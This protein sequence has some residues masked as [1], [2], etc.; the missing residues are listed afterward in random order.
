MFLAYEINRSE[1]IIQSIDMECRNVILTRQ[2]LEHHMRPNA[3]IR[4]IVISGG[5]LL[6]EKSCVRTI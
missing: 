2:K 1:N 6:A 3:V 5:S 4:T